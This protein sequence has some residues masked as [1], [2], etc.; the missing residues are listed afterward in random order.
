MDLGCAHVPRMPA[1]MKRQVAPHPLHIN[2]DGPW[3]VM[4]HGQLLP[5]LAKQC[6]PCWSNQVLA[7]IVHPGGSG[8][9]SGFPEALI[10]QPPTSPPL[11][12]PRDQ[13]SPLP[14][15]GQRGVKQPAIAGLRV[16][17]QHDHRL[18]LAALGLVHRER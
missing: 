18:G 10:L 13:Q 14:R 6:G 4:A 5:E 8:Q 7:G 15:P 16:G 9:P 11:P 3:R 12:P 2:L 17:E 1:P